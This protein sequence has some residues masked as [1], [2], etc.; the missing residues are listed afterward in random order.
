M[1]DFLS[2]EEIER[3]FD[4]ASEGALPMEDPSVAAGPKGAGR[5]ARWL[6]TVDFTRP[7]KFSTDQE[8][9][10]R[11]LMDA[12]CQ[13]AAQRVMAEHRLPIEF[14]VIEAQQL[15]W[16]NAFRLLPD[17]SAYCTIVTAPHDGRMLF[18]CELP[19]LVTA[20]EGLL[21]GEIADGVAGRAL[22]DID[23]IVA[24][25]LLRTCVDVLSSAWFDLAEMT[26][27]LTEMTTLAESV[28][29]APG[30]EP[31]LAITL[32]ARLHKVACTVALLVPYATILPAAAAFSQREEETAHHDEQSEQAVRTSVERVDLT[33]RAEVA[34]TIMS[35]ESL[36]QVQPGDVI[37]L[38]AEVGDEVT[39]F[40]DRTAI[41]HA[42]AGRSGPHR[43]V[44]ITRPVEVEE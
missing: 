12:F 36:L 6:R 14:E 2:P 3:L 5:R 34:D 15:T 26:L 25:R 13:A 18:S 21:G 10:L 16:A 29:V 39:L 22:T 4:R 41:H 30:S 1:N 7:T 44:Q 40:A 11:R 32:E 37:R 8:R 27:D 23:L 33:I 38:D 24:R 42:R 31:T 35:L 17:Q 43:A 20:L 19:L 9:R 28:Q